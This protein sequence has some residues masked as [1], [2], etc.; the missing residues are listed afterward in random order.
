MCGE[1]EGLILETPLKLS[2]TVGLDIEMEKKVVEEKLEELQTQ[3]ASQKYISS[4]M[5]DLGYQRSYCL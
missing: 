3:N 1:K 4:I 2:D 5:K